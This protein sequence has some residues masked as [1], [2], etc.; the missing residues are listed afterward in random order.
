MLRGI[1]KHLTAVALAGFVLL[2]AGSVSAD[3]PDM[4]RYEAA[5]ITAERFPAE[6]AL[7]S[8]QEKAPD[9]G[10][11]VKIGYYE[12]QLS[13]D[14]QLSAGNRE[15][16]SDING[17]NYQLACKELDRFGDK[18]REALGNSW[19]RA[20]LPF[21]TEHIPTVVKADAGG[22]SIL[23]CILGIEPALSWSKVL[24]VFFL[25][26]LCSVLITTVA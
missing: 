2:S 25:F 5:G 12:L 13:A 26:L 20:M 21:Y 19:M 1:K 6:I 8:L 14:R 3:V 11:L 24:V 7:K 15:R 22:L 10:E 17:L 9:G 18:A 16:I 4:T 23:V